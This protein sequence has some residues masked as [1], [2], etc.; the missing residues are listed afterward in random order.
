MLKPVRPVCP[1]STPKPVSDSTKPARPVSETG[2][3]GF[4]QNM[5]WLR[6][7]VE[8][9]RSNKNDMCEA[10]EDFEELD[11]LGQGFTSVTF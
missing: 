11:K 8:D 9:Y 3:A 1:D 7:R 6:N 4:T 10:I 5:Q 2:Q